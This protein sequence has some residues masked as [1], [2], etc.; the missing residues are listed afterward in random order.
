MFPY[1]SAGK[2]VFLFAW[3]Q[4]RQTKTF[5]SFRSGGAILVLP[6]IQSG[7]EAPGTFGYSLRDDSAGLQNRYYNGIA[8]GL[9]FERNDLYNVL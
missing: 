4:A 2:P 3:V 9:A 7:P 5:L 1:N 8:E 6:G